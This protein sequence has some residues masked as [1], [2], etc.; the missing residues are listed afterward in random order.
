MLQ[1]VMSQFSVEV[2]CRTMPKNLAEE[3]SCA[4][5]QKISGGEKIYGLEGIYQD[6]A[7]KTFCL[8]LPKKFVSK[9]LS[10]S[11][12]SVI[13]KVY[14]SGGYV[15]NL[16]RT[17]FVPQNRKTLQGNPSVLFQKLSGSEIFSDKKEG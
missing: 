16:R 3:P 11:L 5:F 10:V 7:S 6:F 2:L 15:T 17:F 12:I 4:V 9:P 13:E 1:R 14:A 8:T